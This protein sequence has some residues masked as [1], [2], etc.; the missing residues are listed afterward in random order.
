MN[1]LRI[2]CL[3]L[4]LASSLSAATWHVSPDGNDAASGGQSTPFR[5]IARALSLAQPGDTVLLQDGTY[6]ETITAPRDGL[7][8]SPITVAAAP[9]ARPVISGLDPVAGPW[10]P[11][12]NGIYSATVPVVSSMANPPPG[13]ATAA[14]TG[15]DLVFING[16]PQPEARFPNRSGS[17]PLNHEGLAVSVGTDLTI[18]ANAFSQLP[19]N[20]LAGTRFHGV[21]GVAWTAQNAVVASN[22]G[23]VVRLTSGT[24]SAP[25]WPA[26]YSDADIDPNTVVM[27]GRVSGT[28]YFYGTLPLLDAEGEWIV[29]RQATGNILRLRPPGGQDPATLQVSIKTRSLVVDINVRNN[30]VIRGLR[31]IGGSARMKGTNLVIEDCEFEHPSHFLAFANGFADNGGLTSGTAI[32]LDGTTGVVRNCVISNSAGTGIQLAGTGHLVSRN[33]LSNVNYSATGADAISVGGRR[34]VVEFNTIRDTGRDGIQLVGSGHRVI[35]NFIRRYARLTLDSGGCYTYG[36]NGVD[37]TTGLPSEIAYN[38][39]QENGNPNDTK[40]RGIYLD[41][42]SRGFVVHHNVIRDIGLPGQNKGIHL[43]GPNIGNAIYHNT[44]IGVL[45]PTQSTFTKYPNNNPSPTFWT[46]ANNHLTYVYQ[47]NLVLPHTVA[48]ETVLEDPANGDYRPRVTSDAVDPLPMQQIITWSTTDGKTGVP[49]DYTLWMQDKTVPFRLTETFGRGVRLPGLNDDLTGLYPDDGAYERDR[50][51]WRPGH[52]GYAAG[53]TGAILA[54]SAAVVSNWT[55]TT[56]GA[57][58]TAGN[59]LEN[60]TPAS[61]PGADLRFFSGLSVPAATINISN[62]LPGTFDANQLHFSGTGTATTV[63]NLSGNPLRLVNNGSTAPA[64]TLGGGPAGFRYNI[65]NPITLDEDVLVNANH[66]GTFAFNGALTGI[67]GLT[68]SGTTGTLILGGN[69]TYSGATRISAGTLQIGNDGVTGTLGSGPVVNNGQLRIDRSGTLTIANDISGSGSLLLHCPSVNDIVRLTGNNTFTGE[70]RLSGGSLRVT[71]VAQLGPAP[72]NIVAHVYNAALR[73]NGSAGDVIL[74]AGFSLLTSNENGAIINEAGN[75]VIEGPV[76][77]T[78]GGGITRIAAS[79]GSLTLNGT[80]TPNTTARTLDLRG[81]GSGVINGNI[82]DA[83]APNTLAGITKADAGTWILNGDNSIAGNTTVSGGSLFINGRHA[84][85]AVSVSSGATLGGKGNIVAPITVNGTLSPGDGFGTLRTNSTISLGSTARV[86]WELE[87][88]SIYGGDQAIAEGALTVTDGARIDVVLNA[89][90]SMVSY[91]GAF[92]RSPR[93]FPVLTGS[94]LTGTFALGSVSEDSFGRATSTYGSFSLQHTAT[95]VNLV[96]T[97]VPGFPMIYEPGIDFSSPTAQPVSVIDENHSLRVIATTPNYSGVTWSWRQVSGPA[98]VS[99]D[100]PASRDT[101]V[102]FSAA[103][104]YVLRCVVANQNGSGAGDLSVKVGPAVTT[105]TVREGVDGALTPAT[106]IRSDTSTWNSGARDQLVVGKTPGVLR[107]LLAFPLSSL[108]ANAFV[109]DASLDLTVCA[110]GSGSTME[111][112][113]IHALNVPF[114]EGTGDGVTASNGSGTGA[115]WLKRSYAPSTPWATA[116]TGS[117]SDYGAAL[118]GSAAAFNPTTTPAGTVVPFTFTPGFADKV[119][120]AGATLHLL[121]KGAN[122]IAGISGFVRFASEDHA[123]V[124]WRPQLRFSYLGNLAPLIDPGVAPAAN[125]GSPVTLAGSVTHGTGLG[126]TFIT[127]PA[128]VTP[129]NTGPANA[130]VV[131]TQAGTYLFRLDAANIHGET[132][133]ALEVVAT[134]DALTGLETWQQAHFGSVTEVGAADSNNDGESN[135]LEFAT[136]QSPLASTLVETR[137]VQNG[138]NIEFTYTR[139]KAAMTDGITFTVEWCDTLSGVTWSPV[140]VTESILSDDGTLQSIRATLPA[141]DA[142]KCFLRLRVSKP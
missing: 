117:G 35:Y 18:T 101:R 125:V 137:L 36:Q 50:S 9:G 94:S 92:W 80:I 109:T 56:G 59:W 78:S 65:A 28:G 10:T 63:V 104:S 124:T 74:P 115:D 14:S 23:T 21:V 120:S 116:G 84:T 95:G 61:G 7:A 1:F 114:D 127:G 17:D 34:Q 48:P 123:T 96:W 64:I 46:D 58:S 22:T 66:S 105:R 77:L 6:R 11:G 54:G 113:N 39:I 141:G 98:A 53:T 128:Q 121:V 119:A 90:G 52:D 4:G 49:A 88:H 15:R 134:G 12:A 106:F 25:W 85:G 136:G 81:A 97:P 44:L 16:V 29:E 70:V 45:P 68:R 8:G 108:P 86:R 91:I 26:D 51:L 129:G 132:S 79:S 75:N 33:Q 5:T 41:N 138:E 126:W 60:T 130:T 2:F 27:N 140:G 103:G 37:S 30:W 76:T 111:P 110:A 131:F 55:G 107:A 73:L 87:R 40:N 42:Y 20:A 67:G 13:V 93:T 47:N 139:S 133:R 72:K 142:G 69:N 31:F 24:L 82:L 122:D 102:H 99:F 112:L 19:A 62:D 71:D 100:N 3:I 135:L 57:W 118:L 83:A 43:G 89:P 38:W 32:L